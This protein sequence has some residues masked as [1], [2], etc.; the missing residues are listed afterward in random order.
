MFQE[1]NA[2]LPSCLIKFN[3]F[4]SW[5]KTLFVFS[6]PALKVTPAKTKSNKFNSPHFKY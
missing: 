3:H 5:L 2:Y 6:S 4:Q 1:L